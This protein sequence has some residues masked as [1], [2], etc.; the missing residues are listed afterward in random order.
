MSVMR[1]QTS[2]HNS[3]IFGPANRSTEKEVL[4]MCVLKAVYISIEYNLS[5]LSLQLLNVIHV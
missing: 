5:D 4:T 3:I 1:S 2:G